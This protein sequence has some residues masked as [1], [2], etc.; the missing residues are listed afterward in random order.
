MIC[1]LL[2]SLE[3]HKFN[4]IFIIEINHLNKA[5]SISRTIHLLRKIEER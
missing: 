3:K 1:Y 4:V 5:K 2:M